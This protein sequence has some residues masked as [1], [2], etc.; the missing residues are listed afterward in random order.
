MSRYRLPSALG[1][2]HW[3]KSLYVSYEP[4]A[5][6]SPMA[7]R[8]N[9]ELRRRQEPSVLLANTNASGYGFK[10]L[11]H[12]LPPLPP[13]APPLPPPPPAT[14]LLAPAPPPI[15]PNIPTMIVADTSDTPHGVS[16][17]V[18]GNEW[19]NMEGAGPS[20]PSTLLALPSPSFVPELSISPASTSSSLPPSPLNL[21]LNLPEV[22]VVAAGDAAGEINALGPQFGWGISSARQAGN[23]Q[24]DRDSDNADERP[25][26][27]SRTSSSG[28]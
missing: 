7:R 13:P 22:G 11:L 19:R 26:K 10:F 6:L 20:T 9:E 8:V 27:R 23:N 24:R 14:P 1:A 25:I 4:Q 17:T 16:M 3:Y 18:G 28:H 21:E 15:A 5:Q 12:P 2:L